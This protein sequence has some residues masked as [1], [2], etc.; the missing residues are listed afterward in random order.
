M[1]PPQASRESSA[2]RRREAAHCGISDSYRCDPLQCSGRGHQ[3]KRLLQDGSAGP[4]EA[5]TEGG[6]AGRGDHGGSGSVLLPAAAAEGGGAASDAGGGRL[7][8]SG[9]EVEAGCRYI[10]IVDFINL[11]RSFCQEDL[12]CSCETSQWIIKLNSSLKLIFFRFSDECCNIVIMCWKVV[13]SLF[14]KGP[15]WKIWLDL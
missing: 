2:S 3:E 1:F 4:Q 8:H 13:T 12:N 10:I 6:A 14:F 9:A 5:Q 7:R 11:I 15:E